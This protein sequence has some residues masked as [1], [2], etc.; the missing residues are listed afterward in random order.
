MPMGFLIQESFQLVSVD[1]IPIVCQAYPIRTVDIKWLSLRIGTAASCRVSKMSKTHE[2]WE[3]SNA[4]A[5]VKDLG[6]HAVPFALVET[7]ARAA[8]CNTTGILATV[9]EQIEGIVDLDGSGGG[10]G[11]RMDYGDDT[12]H[13]EKI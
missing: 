2:A 11:I 9:L 12:A 5:V 13:F 8:G 4:G 7:T 3:V 10:G 6:C 1:Q